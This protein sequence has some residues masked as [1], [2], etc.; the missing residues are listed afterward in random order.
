[1]TSVYVYRQMLNT[2]EGEHWRVLISLAGIEDLDSAE[3][4][5]CKESLMHRKYR[6][7]LAHKR[8]INAWWHMRVIGFTKQ[9][10]HKPV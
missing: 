7:S 2:V 9:I 5:Q 1:M 3:M 8:H 10:N 6:K 4:A